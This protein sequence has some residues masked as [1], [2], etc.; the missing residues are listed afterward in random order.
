MLYPHFFRS[1]L[2]F[3]N[4]VFCFRLVNSTSSK[5]R[6]LDIVTWTHA[7]KQCMSTNHL[8]SGSGIGKGSVSHRDSSHCH[9]TSYYKHIKKYFSLNPSKNGS[10]KSQLFNAV[11]SLYDDLRLAQLPANISVPPY[12]TG[13]YTLVRP[14]GFGFPDAA[15]LDQVPAKD[16]DICSI[17]P[18]NKS[19][20]IWDEQKYY[21]DLQ[22]SLFVLTVKKAGWDCFRHVEILASGALPLFIDIERCPVAAIGL[23]PKKLYSLLLSFPGL[24]MKGPDLKA[25]SDYLESPQQLSVDWTQFDEEMYRLSA[26][27]LMQYARNVLSCEKIATYLLD[28]VASSKRTTNSSVSSQF[29]PLQYVHGSGVGSSINN[30]NII[31]RWHRKDSPLIPHNILFLT[32]T[33]LKAGDY[34]VELL[35]LGL[36]RI[37]DPA[38][39]LDFPR[40]NSIY[41]DPD[42]FNRSAYLDGKLKLYGKGFTFAYRLEDVLMDDRAEAD[43]LQRLKRKEFDLIIVPSVHIEVLGMRV[44]MYVDGSVVVAICVTVSIAH[45]SFYGPYSISSSYQSSHSY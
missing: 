26:Q 23:H 34:M 31:G 35:L 17:I 14:I 13:R 24:L 36:K 15:I 9:D 3:R 39:V 2:L 33:S 18:G 27:A 29:E 38:H 43:V 6:Q 16:K 11:I 32:H 45:D 22:R 20:Y 12:G 28:A 19:T 37:M 41:R 7:H 30:S 42:L 5:E 10:Y 25:W 44:F 40:R 8:I 4:I 1:F 21:D